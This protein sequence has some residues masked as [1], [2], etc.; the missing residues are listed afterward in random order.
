MGYSLKAV[1]GYLGVPA[2]TVRK[3]ESR[4]GL[5]S[6]KRLPNGYREYSEED[7]QRLLRFATERK[8]G[9]PG[10]EAARHAA[11]A[12]P[13]RAAS[14]EREAVLRAARNFDRPS[15]QDLFERE[16]RRRGVMPAF[17]E[18]WLPALASIGASAHAEGGLW[19]AVEHFTTAFL[20]ENI[21]RTLTAR[22]GKPPTLALLAPSGERHELGML[23]A[24]CALEERGISS[25]YLGPDLPIASFLAVLGK[26]NLKGAALTLTGSMPR[27]ELRSLLADLRA[28]APRLRVFVCGQG[29]LRH[30]NLIRE[31]GA[32]FIGTDLTL[33][34]ERI[35]ALLKEAHP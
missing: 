11:A 3:W 19:I 33:G 31:M 17:R 20:R 15:L 28:G 29:S 9:R 30:A 14:R 16:R 26:V 23:A 5:V 34:V 7:L 18:V 1:C 25:L 22:R 10:R 21:L 35:A 13:V 32:V 12:P 24:A 4:H 8:Q 6:P 27:R 2:D